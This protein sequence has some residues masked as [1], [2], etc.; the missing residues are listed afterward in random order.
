M[1]WREILYHEHDMA[2]QDDSL[3][4]VIEWTYSLA[5]VPCNPP[6]SPTHE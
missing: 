3:G 5:V 1:R 2:W 4:P 6:L